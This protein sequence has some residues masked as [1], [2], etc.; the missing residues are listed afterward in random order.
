M[1]REKF[2]HEKKNRFPL[3]IN[4]IKSR[5]EII[6]NESLC[7]TIKFTIIIARGKFWQENNYLS[8]LIRLNQCQRFF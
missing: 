3:L 2:W 6:L 1:T 5:P 4:S 8:L 7:L